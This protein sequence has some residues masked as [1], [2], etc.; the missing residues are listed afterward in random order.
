MW[1][2]LALM[3]MGVDAL[4]YTQL[5]GT[6]HFQMMNR[7]YDVVFGMLFLYVPMLSMGF[8]MLATQ[9]KISKNKK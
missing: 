3:M 4:S 7:E 9:S 5:M 1:Y 2:T 6:D 8:W